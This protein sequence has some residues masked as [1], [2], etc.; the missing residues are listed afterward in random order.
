MVED[1]SK[2]LGWSAEEV[3]RMKFGVDHAYAIGKVPDVMEQFKKYGIRVN[4]N[5]VMYYNT[6]P[7]LIRDHVETVKK[8]L[9]PVKSYIDAGMRPTIHFE[10]PGAKESLFWALAIFINRKMDNGEVAMPEESI[11]RVQA[12]KLAT[13]WA[14]EY[15]DN[16][17]KI[18]SL[19]KGKLADFIVID[20]DFFTIPEEEICNIKNLMTVVGGKVVYKSPD[21]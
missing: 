2:E 1:T 9:M 11:D 5:P 17:N 13:V 7:L 16:E 15:V 4:F 21:M 6:G 14:A 12:L 18:G 8:F 20:K 3:A 19:E 10:F